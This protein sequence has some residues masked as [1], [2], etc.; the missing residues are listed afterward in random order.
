M[1]HGIYS[2]KP[3]FRHV[4]F[5][6]GLNVVLAERQEDSG[7]TKT[8][9]SIGKSTLIKIINF[10]LGSGTSGNV[11]RTDELMEWSFTI[12]ITLL[13]QRVRATRNVNNPSRIFLTGETES[14]PI[15]PELDKEK[16]SPFLPLDK[17]RLLLGLAFFDIPQTSDTS[18]RS[19][20]S[21]F[22][23]SGNEAYI[24]PLKF[25][26][27]QANNVAHIYN[28]FF[29]GLDSHYASQWVDL[30]KKSKT[31]KA[32]GNAIKT[33]VH[34]TQGELEARKIE[35]EEE[36][37]K[38][39]EI[40]SSF[41]VHE[42]YKDIQVEA[43]QLTVDLHNLANQNIF[44][45]QK[46][47]HYETSITEEKAPEKTKLEKIYKEVG[48]VFPDNIKKTLEESDL[49]H[50]KIISN[51]KSFLNAE[52]VRIK[53][54]IEKR[55]RLIKDLTVKRSECMKILDTHGALEE[56]S[57]L[58]EQHSK[59]SEKLENIK[60]RIEQ[61][62]DN[63]IKIKDI[64][65]SKIELDKKAGIDYEE[66]RKLWERAIKLF[67][68]TARVLYGTSGKFVI[69]ISDKGYKFEVNIPGD[70]GSGI[71]KMEIFCYDLMVIC[72]Q[73]IL[74]RNI[75]FLI[76]DSTI[77][78]GVDARQVA[79]AIEQAAKKSK[80]FDFQYIMAIN[81]DMVP[82]NDFDNEFKFDEH[83]RLH[84]TDKDASGSLLGIR[85]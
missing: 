26:A 3:T 41:K 38:S 45:N 67:N 49:F 84:L 69:D 29:V 54:G 24:S 21:Y 33:G 44:D 63:S 16:N 27:H 28:T 32:L 73:R 20:M 62:K 77:Y 18:I 10:C 50:E 7:K 4:E 19:M 47:K 57:R 78:E 58:Q 70:H 6:K 25:F 8:V 80:E 60:A 13:N 9:N 22:I 37:Q 15:V 35:L 68:E 40:L 72:M 30:D 46:L 74:K 56:H 53:N 17:W 11:L 39:R 14:W 12:D 42:K 36:L 59:I 71:S 51:R 66:K 83:I 52:I 81:S 23:R 79:K 65:T 34:E 85:Y 55:K 82:Y 76:H 75:D 64:K 5:I 2:N 61:I 31:L 48:L 43:N 1:I